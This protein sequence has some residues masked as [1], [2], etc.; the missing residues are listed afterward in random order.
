MSMVHI[1]ENSQNT[2]VPYSAYNSSVHNKS[3]D[4]FATIL[5]NS[6]L[7]C[8]TPHTPSYK[9]TQLPSPY[10]HTSTPSSKANTPLTQL[11]RSAGY[12]HSVTSPP[13]HPPGK[14]LHS[15]TSNITTPH[16]TDSAQDSTHSYITI[17]TTI[18]NICWYTC[19][20][21]CLLIHVA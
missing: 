20:F 10:P 12:A 14:H 4:S 21:V 8:A 3:D 19:W 5:T 1:P 9:Y 18:L 17:P 13:I 15:T 7:H 2:L 6:E 16:D 11:L